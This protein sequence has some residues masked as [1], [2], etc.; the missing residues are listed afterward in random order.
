MSSE[1]LKDL[2]KI[3]RTSTTTKKEKEVQVMT[4]SETFE[5]LSNRFSH[6]LMQLFK[7]R[8]KTQRNNISKAFAYRYFS[9][10]KG[11]D[12]ALSSEMELDVKSSVSKDSKGNN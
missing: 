8:T 9:C 5:P 1:H 4:C 12:P 6:R 2:Q 11:K 7:H 10:M 3:K